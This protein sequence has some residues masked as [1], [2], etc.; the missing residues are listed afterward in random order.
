M[1]TR[2]ARDQEGVDIVN[3]DMLE[4]DVVHNGQDVGV[5]L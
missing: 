1:C 3:E 4:N 2:P 5:V